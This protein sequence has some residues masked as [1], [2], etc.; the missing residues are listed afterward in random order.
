[1]L[2]DQPHHDGF[3]QDYVQSREI[4]TGVIRISVKTKL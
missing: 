2:R 1:M 4:F 3:P